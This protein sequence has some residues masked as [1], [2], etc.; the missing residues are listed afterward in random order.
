MGFVRASAVGEEMRSFAASDLSAAEAYALLVGIVVPRPVAWIT[1]VNAAGTVNAAPFSCYTFVC[2]RPPILAVNIGRRGETLKDTAANIAATGQFVVNVAT[3][4]TLPQMHASSAEYAPADSEVAA[5][6]L[7]TTAS[8]HVTPPRLV[9]S[10]IA[11]ECRIERLLE[12]GEQ[13]S[14]LLIG[15]VLAFHVAEALLTGNRVAVDRFHPIA[16]LGGPHY[17]TLGRVISQPKVGDAGP[18]ETR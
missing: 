3:E 7:E 8:L 11:M 15:E 2:N 10:P 9:C 5:L 4:D 1:T 13:K 18:T 16:R 12:L 6:G 17:A 14:G